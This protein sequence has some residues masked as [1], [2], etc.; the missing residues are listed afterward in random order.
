MGF[1]SSSVYLDVVCSQLKIC[2]YHLRCRM[3]ESNKIWRAS[4]VGSAPWELVQDT[5]RAYTLRVLATGLKKKAA[6]RIYIGNVSVLN[7]AWLPSLWWH[8]LTY[9]RWWTRSCEGI[10]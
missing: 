1:R 2:A 4:C 3:L 8:G 5:E 10:R 9:R 7:L 6:K